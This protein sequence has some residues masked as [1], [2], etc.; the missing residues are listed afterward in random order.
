MSKPGSL[1]TDDERETDTSGTL[2]RRNVLSGLAASGALLLGAKTVTAD[3]RGGQAIV[4][5]TAYKENEPFTITEG[6]IRDDNGFERQPYRCSDSGRQISFVAWKFEYDDLDKGGTLYTRDNQIE[7]DVT[8]HWGGPKDCDA[9]DE[10]VQTSFVV[11][12]G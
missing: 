11:G 4:E 6:P 2:S 1:G 3:G 5:E 7:T 8:Y 10:W 9:D 12:D